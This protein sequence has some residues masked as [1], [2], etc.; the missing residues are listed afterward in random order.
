MYRLRVPLALAGLVLF[1]LPLAAEDSADHRAWTQ[2]ELDFFE[3]EVRPVLMVS[4][5]DCHGAD[6]QESDIRVDGRE[7]L[8]RGNDS[9][10]AVTPGNP[11]ESLL[12]QVVRYDGDVQMPPDAKLPQKAIDALTRWVEMGAPWPEATTPLSREASAEGHW[13]YQPVRQPE[14]PVVPGADRVQTPVDAFI[15]ARLEAA[16]LEL[17]RPAERTTLIRRLSYDLTGLPPTPAEVARFVSDEHPDA[18]RLLVERLLDSPH[19]GERWGRY[20]LD[21]ARYSDTKGYVFQEDRNYKYAY[22]F[23]DWVI[24]SFNEDLPY[25][26]FLMCQIAGDQLASEEFNVPLAAMGFLT[27]GRRFLNN[28]HDIIDDRI[29]V[30]TRGMM[31]LTVACAR[32][33]DHKYDPIP[34]ADYYSLYGVFSASQ[35]GLEPLEE[36]T[37]AYQE[38]LAKREAAIDEYLREQHALLRK[39]I[40]ADPAAYLA[41]AAEG[42]YAARDAEYWQERGLKEPSRQL[43]ARWT[44]F[45]EQVVHPRDPIFGPWQQLAALPAEGFAERAAE[46]CREYAEG[47]GIDNLNPWVSAMF[48]DFEPQSF[49]EVIDRYGKL[50]L[51]IQ[52]FWDEALA[53]ATAQ[54]RP[55]PAG[56]EEPAAEAIRQLLHGPRS[57]AQ[58]AEDE[59]EQLLSRPDREKL[60]GLRN[61]VTEWRNSDE[62]PRQ[63]MVL[64]DREGA[65]GNP[66]ILV[67]GD[68]RN[69]G[70][71]V[72]RQFL[73]LVAG[74]QRRPFEQGSGRLELARAIVDPENPLTA[75]VWVN[76]VWEYLVG[77]GL[78]DTPSD[79]G[80]RSD[81]PTHPELLDYLAARFMAEGWSTKWLITQIVLSS[82]Y[83]QASDHRAE[84]AAVDPENRLVWRMNRRRLDFEALR[85]SLLAVADSLEP[86]VYGVSVDINSSP[87]PRRRTIYSHIDRQNLPGVFR[88]FDFASPDAHAPRRY[89]TTVPQQALYLMNHPFAIEK[90]QQLVARTDVAESPDARERIVR[91]YE[92]LYARQPSDE[93]IQVGLEFIEGA[94]IAEQEKLEPWVRYAQALLMSNEFTFLD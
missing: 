52:E 21:I 63:A 66:R 45:L 67:R 10:P 61:R 15:L 41:A 35:E 23:R 55:A 51:R 58:I 19:F 9:G 30:V 72:P 25:D 53:V 40:F 68:P 84:A 2:E 77:R 76:R 32:C 37:A 46:L 33:H 86:K 59:S 49:D 65:P 56:L 42:Q 62:G 3:R 20:W 47:R 54:E 79:F 8:L 64:R 85:D 1:H 50:L 17:N 13:A 18:A 34:T 74:D 92:V 7:H 82:T 80:L 73:R 14:V 93:E 27:V 43:L 29:D 87:F 22:V 12:V 44:R 60:R 91:L 39:H 26:Q 81:A 38:E 57:P 70:D 83:Q 71:E 89:L 31:G 5:I 88:T 90:A 94:P 69:V 6:M 24:R 11:E 28:Q 48:A 78:V 16:G 75:R 36:G 4:C